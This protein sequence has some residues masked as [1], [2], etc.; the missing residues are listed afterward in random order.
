MTTYI[1]NG[2]K[3]LIF[4]QGCESLTGSNVNRFKKQIQESLQLKDEDFSKFRNELIYRSNSIFHALYVS[5]MSSLCLFS[6]QGAMGTCCPQIY[7]H[8]IVYSAYDLYKLI[9]AQT[10]EKDVI[11]HHILMFLVY[12]FNYQYI[13]TDNLRDRVLLM[14]LLVEWST[15]FLNFSI[16]LYRAG[17]RGFWL[18]FNGIMTL[19]MYFVFRV[20]MF[21]YIVY[22]AWTYHIFYMMISLFFWGLNSYWFIK[23]TQKFIGLGPPQNQN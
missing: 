16:M 10:I 2:L 14:A 20:V 13:G 17:Y 8:V 23:L 9:K 3:E 6:E 21:S 4:F 7:L 12:L 15:P 5:I 11:T 22:V 1:I 18:N 19:I